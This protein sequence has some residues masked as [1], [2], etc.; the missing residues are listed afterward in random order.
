VNIGYVYGFNSFALQTGGS[1]HVHNLI[2]SLNKLGCSIHTFEP[3]ENPQCMTYPATEKG[4]TAF[5][6]NIDILYIRIDGWYLSQTEQK[7]RCMERI[8]SKPI[9]WEINASSE[10]RLRIESLTSKYTVRGWMLCRLRRRAKDLKIRSRIRSEERFRRNY[11]RMVDAAICVSS[12]LTEYAG[13]KLCIS[14]SVVVPNGSD[15]LLFSP[16]KRSKDLFKDHESTFKVI[17][18][19]D[20]RWPW[21]GI[22]Y[23][24]KLAAMARHEEHRILFVVL[25]QSPYE[26]DI[27]AENLLVFNRVNYF[28]VPAYV[29][30]ADLCL[31]LYHDF[32]WSSYGF[33]LSP[34][35]LFDYMACGKPIVA[36][37]LGQI[38]TVIDDGKDGLLTTND[39]HDIYDKILLCL[40]HNDKAQEIGRSARQKV[41]SYY[42]WERAAKSTI[43]LFTALMRG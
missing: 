23:V 14:K 17:Y 39:I 22:D 32:H 11:A 28:D 8:V 42:N 38:S 25:D 16:K 35:K 21:Q 20:S 37:A 27:K 12:Q 7:I 29:A 36:S 30:S 4:T 40:E 3:E 19:G 2:E 6:N 33:T 43:E 1:I 41:V 24:K 31:C 15:P 13:E 34:L 26:S 9:V 5:L 18:I 10:E